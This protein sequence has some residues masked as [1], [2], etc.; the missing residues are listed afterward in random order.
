MIHAGV[1]GPAGSLIPIQLEAADTPSMI[2]RKLAGPTGIPVEAQ[3]VMLGGARDRAPLS[4]RFPHHTLR[5]LLAAGVRR[6]AVVSAVRL[7]RRDRGAWPELR[8]KCSTVSSK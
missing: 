8:G 5:S 2:K 3:K 6:Q 4:Q 7:V 1:W